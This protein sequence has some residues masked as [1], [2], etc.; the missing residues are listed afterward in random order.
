M[1]VSTVPPVQRLVERAGSL[2]DSLAVALD[3]DGEIVAVS[4]QVHS[5]VLRS[6]CRDVPEPPVVSVP[7]IL[8]DHAGRLLVVPAGDGPA[9]S[10]HLVEGVAELLIAQINFLNTEPRKHELKSQLFHRL[11]HGLVAD[12]E[13]EQREGRILGLDLARPRAV[14]LI[15]A[16]EYVRPSLRDEEGLDEAD[17]PAEEW[18]RAQAII[19]RVVRFFR[20]PNDAICS[21]MGGG[22]IAVLKASSSRDLDLW[23]SHDATDPQNLSSWSNL[24]ALKRATQALLQSLERETGVRFAISVGR[25]HPGIRGLAHS[26]EDARA[27]LT[28]G[29]RVS[30][31]GR[32]YCLDELGMAALVGITDERTRVDLASYLLRPLEHEPQ[33]TET[34]IAFFEENCS[35]AA[36]ATK[37]LIHR[38]T[39]NYRLEKITALT[40]LNPKRFD[41]AMVI[42]FALLLQ[43]LGADN[44]LCNRTV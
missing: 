44:S 37:L 19:R 28:I 35:P 31:P 11:L 39:L 25:Y 12:E 17:V 30:A 18:L 13:G 5:G 43:Q 7:Y 33:L 9:L 34:L 21:Y 40:G 1:T 38:N 29:R 4:A 22:E 36:T 26:N 6:L 2:L 14:I 8:P 23:A 3:N 24:A 15:D 41:D 10:R 16:T 20:L 42:R 27:A 32:V